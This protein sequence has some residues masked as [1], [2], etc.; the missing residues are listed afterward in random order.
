MSTVIVEQPSHWTRLSTIDAVVDPMVLRFGERFLGGRSACRSRPEATWRA[1]AADIGAVS[2]FFDQLLTRDR[3][4][5]FNYGDTFDA[6][7]DLGGRFLA[8]VNQHEDLLVEVDVRYDAYREAKT[9]ALEQVNEL[10]QGRRQLPRELSSEVLRHLSAVEYE[11]HPDVTPLGL[12]DPSSQRLAAFLLGGLVFSAYAQQ[13][14]VVHVVQP[15]RARLFAAV[16]LAS[17]NLA[18][19]FERALFRQLADVVERAGGTSTTLMGP[20]FLPLLLERGRP[21]ESPMH[22][23]DRALAMRAAPAMR[24]YRELSRALTADWAA[25]GR[26]DP[27]ARAALRRQAG[28]VAKELGIAKADQIFTARANLMHLGSPVDASVDLVE[29]GSRLRGWVF[30]GLVNRGVRKLLAEAAEAQVSYVDISKAL[31]SRWLAA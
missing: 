21:R 16:S 22:L 12:E 6:G 23:L 14:G 28:W 25:E 19:D 20:T 2:L 13:T 4:P 15:K 27:N 3:I 1:L 18:T 10:V 30:P 8:A 11:W 7:L 29:A 31:R 5:M 26:I 24:D 9:A 17:P